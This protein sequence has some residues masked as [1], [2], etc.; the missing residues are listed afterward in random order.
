MLFFPLALL[1]IDP[2]L[3]LFAIAAFLVIGVLLTSIILFTKAKF[4]SQ[5]ACTIRINHDD[6]LT[7]VTK[8]GQTLLN[9]LTSSG[10]PIPSPCGGKAT[11]KQCR[12][13]IIKGAG[14][15]IETDKGTF[16]KKQLK[17]GW[18]LSCQTKMHGDLDILVD[19][20]CLSISEIEATVI[21]NENV[22]TF[23]KELI[24]EVPKTVDVSYKSGEYF[25]FKV[26]PFKTNTEDWKQT[27]EKKYWPDW[28]KF[29]LF[30]IPIDFSS[31]PT[32]DASV[33]RAYSMASYPEEG[34][35]LKFNIRIATPPFV[36]GKI[37]EAIPWGICSS[38]TFSLKPGDKVN[39]LGPF[40]ESL[41]KNDDRELIFLIGGAGSSFGRS[42]IMHLFRTEKTKR[43]LSLWYGAR[44]L[45][46]NIYEEDY[47][48]LAQDFQN[49]QYNLVLSEPLAEDLEAGW[50]KDD[51][52]R[53]N[54]L[55]R[56]FEQ[57]QLKKMEAPEDCL[58]YVCGPPLHNSSVMKLLDDYG[59][60][61][62]NI[63][64]DDFGS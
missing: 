8:G 6:S 35:I 26:P 39:L 41:M 30:G 32:G 23:I 5:D 54:F 46:E 11:C 1:G 17:E 20:S 16:T 60:S 9:A 29:K 43:K 31:L 53:T 36:Q 2:V 33:I 15:P 4:V 12:V 40:G 28:E 51:P 10:I 19:P 22:A 18:R 48:K 24:V 44:S 47:R 50:P 14:E 56:A 42:H 13:Q 3:T 45:K 57:G 61:R 62:E 21:S 64:L 58:Y 55:F 34:N 38:W 27:M 7:K 49:F 37:N 59:V 63:V 52:I 25:Q